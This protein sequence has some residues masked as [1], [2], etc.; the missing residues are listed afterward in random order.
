MRLSTGQTVIVDLGPQNQIQSI[1]LPTTQPLDILGPVGQIN[2]QPVVL[3]QQIHYP[4][5][6]LT[7]II[8]RN[9]TAPQ[10]QPAAFGQGPESIQ[11]PIHSLQTTNVR[12]QDH[13]IAEIDT[14]GGI[15]LTDLG[16]PSQNPTLKIG[17]RLAVQGHMAIVDSRAMIVADH[18]SP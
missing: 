13:L 16:P 14:P 4:Q 15:V 3:A 10:P 7:L 6:G 11:G 8:N 2:G 1:R 9:L 5:S 12:G 18:V 17:D